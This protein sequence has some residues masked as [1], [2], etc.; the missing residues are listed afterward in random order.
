[1]SDERPLP[2][3]W[4]ILAPTMNRNKLGKHYSAGYRLMARW[5]RLSGVR[6]AVGLGLPGNIDQ[7]AQNRSISEL[8]RV[9]GV[10]S[11]TLYGAM[12]R[13]RPDL[14]EHCRKVG[15]KSRKEIGAAK[16]GMI[17]SPIPGDFADNAMSMTMPQLIEYYKRS[18]KTINR[19]LEK[20]PQSVRDAVLENGQR[21]RDQAASVGGKNMARNRG[22]GGQPFLKP[23]QSKINSH[24]II[25]R[26]KQAMRYLQRY[27]PCYPRSV[28]HSILEGYLFRG[29]AMT[30]AEIIAEATKR[31]WNP[32]AWRELAA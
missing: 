17:A 4:H 3:D 5:A 26:E 2:D 15:M 1:M 13:Q 16:G 23:M 12:K 8:A 30:G 31:G 11:A 25:S 20:Q 6:P 9:M 27:A 18:R 29:I 32:D 7:L 10:C 28:H 24:P 14:F 22:N 19:W 21:R